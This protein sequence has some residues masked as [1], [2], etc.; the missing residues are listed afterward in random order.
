MQR[1]ISNETCMEVI[2]RTEEYKNIFSRRSTQ[3]QTDA[4]EDNQKVPAEL[5]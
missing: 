4:A 3:G 1:N 2:S 5:S